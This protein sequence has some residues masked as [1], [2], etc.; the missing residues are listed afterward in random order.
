M[1]NESFNSRTHQTQTL[2]HLAVGAVVLVLL[3]GLTYVT[4]RL[5]QGA[6]LF[7]LST[8]GVVALMIVMVWLA[9]K[10]IE[11]VAGKEE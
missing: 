2:R 8:F 5:G 11:W 4:F 9:L 3:I 7:A 6:L 1:P 10:A